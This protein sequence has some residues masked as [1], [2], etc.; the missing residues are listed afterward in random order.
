M[1]L[2][3]V[4]KLQTSKNIK[5]FVEAFTARKRSI[6][7]GCVAMLN[8]LATVFLENLIL[9]VSVAKLNKPPNVLLNAIASLCHCSSIV[10]LNAG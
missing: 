10:P 9:S 8:G 4:N 2:N 7:T 5:N 6:N 1:Q 3:I